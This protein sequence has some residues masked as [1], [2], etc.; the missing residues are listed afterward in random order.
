MLKVCKPLH[1]YTNASVGRQRAISNL[2]ANE[3]A[4][5]LRS[6]VR[7]LVGFSPAEFSLNFRLSHR[8]LAV[9]AVVVVGSWASAAVPAR[10]GVRIP[11]TALLQVENVQWKQLARFTPV[12]NGGRSCAAFTPPQAISERAP[13]GLDN[14]TKA[15][16]NFVVTRNGEVSGIVV[17]HLSAGDER[18]LIGAVMGWRFRPATCD[19]VATE[20]EADLE[21]QSRN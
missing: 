8:L 11:S 7:R 14:D 21:L 1:T 18:D 17:L 10:L 3:V 15:R 9:T 6:K 5:G 4:G 16:L 19:G 2:Q 13:V 20:S 12:K